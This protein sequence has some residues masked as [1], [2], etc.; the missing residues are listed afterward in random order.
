MDQS[1]L[2]HMQETQKEHE[3]GTDEARMPSDDFGEP[4]L[5]EVSWAL[6][7]GVWEKLCGHSWKTKSWDSTTTWDGERGTKHCRNSRHNQ[8]CLSGKLILR[9]RNQK[10]GRGNQDPPGPTLKR[11]K[12]FGRKPGRIDKNRGSY[13]PF[14]A[15]ASSSASQDYLITVCHC[16]LFLE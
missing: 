11:P 5:R 8:N 3:T 2:P 9:A 12:S 14:Q 7:A 16:W 10:S 13:K 15:L 4:A 1:H 6:Q